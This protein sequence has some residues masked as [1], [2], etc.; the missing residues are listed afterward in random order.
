M[1]LFKY[2]NNRLKP[3]NEKDPCGWETFFC[4]QI[5]FIIMFPQ[6]SFKLHMQF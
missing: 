4:F 1:M 6:T 3:F 5:K 2:T